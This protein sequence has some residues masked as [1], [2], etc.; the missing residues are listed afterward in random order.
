MWTGG[1]AGVLAPVQRFTGMTVTVPRRLPPDTR[2]RI[3]RTYRVN[4]GGTGPWAVKLVFETG[5]HGY[6]GIEETAMKDPPILEGRTGVIRRN[7]RRVL[8]LLQRQ[9]PAAAGLAGGGHDLLDQ[10]HAR[11]AAVGGHD[12]RDRALGPAAVPARA[13]PRGQASVQ[14]PVELAGSTP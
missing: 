5:Y 7:G 9:A 14:L 10:Q 2:L 6:W 11:R 4:T 1:L 13:L 12:A 3:R 8:D